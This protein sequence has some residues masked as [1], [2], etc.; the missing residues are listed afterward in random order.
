MTTMPQ[1]CYH[2][3]HVVVVTVRWDEARGQ[4]E[5][6]GDRARA[7]RVKGEGG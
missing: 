2:S 3:S 4:G 1:P 5:G 7:M 6:H